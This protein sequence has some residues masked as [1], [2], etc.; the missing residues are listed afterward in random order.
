M[1]VVCFG[2]SLT[3]CPGPG[4]RFSDILADRFPDH[5]FLNA[6][7]SGDAFPSA[8]ERFAAD[9]LALRPDVVLLELGANDWHADARPPQAWGRDL[10]AL[11]TQTHRA[12]ARAVVLGVFG[13]CRDEQGRTLPKDAGSDPR[14]AAW[15]KI[16]AD[17]IRRHG[18]PYVANIQERI[19]HDRRAWTDRNHPNEYG[20]R[21]V[22]DAIEPVLAE[23]FSQAAR[24]IRKPRL[25]TLADLWREA[26]DLA[27]D[28]PAVVEGGRRLTYREA[29]VQV[30]RL[31]AGLW[32]AAGERRPRVAALLPNSP[33]YVLLYW[34]V[35]R[36]SG[37][38]VPLN[39]WLPSDALARILAS[40]GPHVLVTRDA[41]QARA[42]QPATHETGCA[43]Y[44]L[45]GPDEGALAY[46][47][48]RQA[49][50]LAPDVAADHN[51][52]A[53]LMHTSGTTDEPK[54]AM[55]RHMD[56]LFNVAAAVNA[57]DF[58]PED[59]H[60]L[61]NPMFHC[62]A[63]YSQLPVAA[64]QKAPL[65]LAP[66]TAPDKVLAAMARERVTT[67][68][69]VPALLQ[70][71]LAVRDLERYDLAALRLVAFAG[72]PMPPA[73]V[74]DLRARFPN[75]ALHNFYGLTESICMT[76]RL[77]DADLDDHPRAIGRTLPFV[78]CRIQT[79]DGREAAPG[80][81]GELLLAREVVIPGYHG[82]PG[83]LEASS[84]RMH[85]RTWW[86]TGDLASA[87]EQGFYT[88]H[89]RKKDVILVGGEN[90]YAAQVEAVLCELPDVRE[91]AVRGAPATEARASLGEVVEAYVVP[92]PGAHLTEE[93]VR[94]HCTR[95]LAVYMVPQ[96][97]V[98]VDALARNAAGKVD[99]GALAQSA[100]NRTAAL[101]KESP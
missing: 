12:G 14:G 30:Q 62:T 66:S 56:L 17:L 5:T 85:G 86:P 73:A 8:R 10:E 99:K 35:Q 78:D 74:R 23:I 7:K 60:L 22:A 6:G 96:R 29:D 67:C 58:V 52:L 54:G 31:A 40:V 71:M 37:V 42:L 53:I 61:V 95:R 39:T 88:L 2:D 44:A 76:H 57:H 87:D 38:M 18:C 49:P 36:A 21:Y 81:V 33:D 84:V 4:Q 100:A 45:A 26:V 20:N 24:Q 82:R 94:R 28:R 47:D 75:V 59:V 90:V 64:Y 46:D 1:R 55:M 79:Q 97:V 69:T 89:G 77:R 91:A 34:A 16:E 93:Q 48:L 65:V 98:F 41:R 3:T 11:I 80:E 50:G 63:L 51:D 9:A 101:P 25:H 15:H 83:R 72:S 43:V 70:R 13:P 32:R 19:L 27:P 68:L 92:A